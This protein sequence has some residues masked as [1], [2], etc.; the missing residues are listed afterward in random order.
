MLRRKKIEKGVKKLKP[1]E[2]RNK[3]EF[4]IQ[5]YIC[6]ANLVDGRSPLYFGKKFYFEG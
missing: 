6:Y 1:F 5:V 3:I 4:K 2:T